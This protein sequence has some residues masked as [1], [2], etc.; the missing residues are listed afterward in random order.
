MTIVYCV[1]SAWISSSI[2]A[3]A[4]GSSA[5]QGSS[6]NTTSGPTASARAMHKHSRALWIDLLRGV[7]SFLQSIIDCTS[8]LRRAE[9][10]P[11]YLSD[12]DSRARHSVR[13]EHNTR[14]RFATQT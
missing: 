3:V 7:R 12:A 13:A 4:I 11:P 10:Y 9:D 14:G 8:K 5:E 6:I 2:F 1:L